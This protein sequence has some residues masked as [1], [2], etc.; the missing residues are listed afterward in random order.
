[1]TTCTCTTYGNC[2]VCR[3]AQPR[4]DAFR[5]DSLEWVFGQWGEQAVRRW[6]ESQGKFVIPTTCIED[7]G[8]PALTRLLER[9]VLPDFQAFGVGGEWWE[10]KTKTEPVRHQISGQTRTGLDEDL[11]FQYLRV[12]QETGLP[13]HLAM[14]FDTPKML[15]AQSF[16]VLDR[17]AHFHQGRTEPFGGK[18][19]VF[20]NIDDFERILVGD[21]LDKLAPAAPTHPPITREARPW[22]RKSPDLGSRQPRLWEDL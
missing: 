8:A 15:L 14:V 12:Q 3:P 22:D 7:G 11:W 1:M 5:K 21:D 19:L 6:L 9:V 17:W 13:G 2:Q 18:R 4:R 10:V 16:S 20:W